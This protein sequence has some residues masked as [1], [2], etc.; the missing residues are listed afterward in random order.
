[1]CR[2]ILE[3]LVTSG[4]LQLSDPQHMV[5]RENSFPSKYITQVETD[6]R[7]PLSASTWRQSQCLRVVDSWLGEQD[8]DQEVILES[9]AVL[10][11]VCAVVSERC[12]A[13]ASVCVAELCD[14]Q[15]QVSQSL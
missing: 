12:A 1:M 14:R 10:Q 3:K 4:L 7:S 8:Q 9:L 15:D 11:S 2:N 6:G 13:L 5:G